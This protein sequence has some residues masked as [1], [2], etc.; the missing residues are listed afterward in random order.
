LRRNRGSF[1][2]TV[3]LRHAAGEE[4]RMRKIEKGNENDEEPED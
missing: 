4:K 1:T 3:L 2:G